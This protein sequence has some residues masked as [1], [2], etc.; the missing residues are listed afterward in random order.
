MG[1]LYILV[2]MQYLFKSW[3]CFF[4][5]FT[6]LSLD[7]WFSRVNSTAPATIAALYIVCL[8]SKGKSSW[9]KKGQISP[10]TNTN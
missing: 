5:I 1:Y 7:L 2:I 6:R 4:L 10:V 3:C 8:K 9:G